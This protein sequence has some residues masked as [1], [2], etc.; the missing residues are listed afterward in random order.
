MIV[1]CCLVTGGAGFIGSHLVD[2]LMGLK[3]RVK[4]IDN[5]STGNIKNLERWLGN[6][7]FE[8]VKGDLLNSEEL[9]NAAREVD[10]IFHIAA[11]PEVRVELA[12]PSVHFKQSVVATFNVLEAA[13]CSSEVRSL[14]FSSSS[15]VYGDASFLPTPESCPPNP[16]S[17]YG[18]SKLASEALIAGFASTYEF[19]A[20]IFRLANVVGP[21]C[22]HGAIHDF[23]R[24]L[25]KNPAEL[26]V[27]GDGTQSKSYLYVED[28]VEGILAGLGSEEKVSIFNLGSDDKIGVKAIA[29]LVTEEMEL[30]DTRIRFTGGI[31]GGRGWRGDVK[32]MMLDN[33]KLKRTGWK[34]KYNSLEAVRETIRSL[35]NK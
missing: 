10:T 33:A 22:Q 32:F 21:R 17:I 29:Q 8:F 23:I 18:A 26:E 4:V 11:N 20:S 24:K 13:R 27:L 9:K 7:A 19:K 12:D 28:C 14:A 3:A 5:L 2:H 25:R 30:K 34:A 15:T 35:L 31:D 6:P 1:H 16:I